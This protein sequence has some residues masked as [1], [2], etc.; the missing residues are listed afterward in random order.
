MNYKKRNKTKK[1][2]FLCNSICLF[3]ASVTNASA[4]LNYFYDIVATTQFPSNAL[5]GNIVT[6]T[7][8]YYVNNKYNGTSLNGISSI[9]HQ[10]S[11]DENVLTTLPSSSYSYS[12]SGSSWRENTQKLKYVFTRPGAYQFESIQRDTYSFNGTSYDQYP[13]YLYGSNGTITIQGDLNYLP[14]ETVDPGS[15]VED[16]INYK[17]I[18]KQR[19]P[20]CNTCGGG[21]RGAIGPGLGIADSPIYAAIGSGDAFTIEVAQNGPK[22]ASIVLAESANASLAFAT[23]NNLIAA[24]SMEL[25]S[26]DAPIS[27][28]FFDGSSDIA[29]KPGF[30][31][32][33]ENEGVDKFSLIGNG[34]DLILG[35]IFNTDD[36]DNISDVYFTSYKIN[37]SPVPL[38][39]S[40]SFLCLGIIFL[41]LVQSNQGKSKF[42]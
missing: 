20:R 39:S 25:S 9:T 1:I 31:F 13:L 10:I 29:L 28:H 26:L 6:I 27:L 11:M 40:L 22:I 16:W 23:S 19:I 41:A 37:S 34:S 42:V 5:T 21:V 18:E 17:T 8:K 15:V 12:L 30:L 35:L 36:S 38:S 2:H 32:A 4:T 3:L 33:F 14:L 7:D 24:T